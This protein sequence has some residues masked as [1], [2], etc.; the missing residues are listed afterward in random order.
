MD[1]GNSL[2]SRR[3]GVEPLTTATY[4]ALGNNT[5]SPSGQ[6]LL[7]DAEGRISTTSGS[8]TSASYWYDGEGHRVKQ[9]V[10]G[11]TTL[12]AYDGL[13]RLAVEDG[14]PATAS[15]ISYVTTDLLGSV[16][17]VTNASG[18]VVSRHDYSP[19]GGE[20]TNAART[21]LG[22][23]YGAVDSSTLRFTSQQHDGATGLDYFGAR[24]FSSQ[25]GRSMSVDPVFTWKETIADPQRWNRYAYARGNPLRYTD[26]TGKYVCDAAKRSDCGVIRQAL[27]DVQTAMNALPAKSTGHKSLQNILNFY[28]KEGLDSGVTVRVGASLGVGGTGTEK[29]RTTISVDLTQE[30]QQTGG[31][32]TALFRPEVASTMAHE[33]R[34]GIDQQRDGM[35]SSRAMTKAT[36][37]RAAK[38]EAYV[39]QGTN[40]DALWGTWT[41][42]GGFD[43][44]AIEREAETATQMWCD[45]GGTC[46]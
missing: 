46:P 14:V 6:T 37:L 19:F 38:T 45:A 32:N 39:W 3:T 43:P 5:G 27:T 21:S 25:Q 12:F 1:P 4:D 24:Y 9:T 35:P 42:A 28:G 30:A 11:V 15:G 20:L 23:S 40:T 2:R 31:R 8:G 33:G 26:P 44:A 36:E 18:Q 29:G 17:L 34:H 13:G 22:I 16:R 41:R 10:N 7:Y